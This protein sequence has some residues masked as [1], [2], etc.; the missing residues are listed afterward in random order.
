MGKVDYKKI[1]L[2]F[3]MDYIQK[4]AKEDKEWFKSIALDEEGKYNH[5]IAKR[6]FAERYMPDIIPKAKVTQKKSDLLKNW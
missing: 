3:M 6:Q 2:E 5:L 4:N 1:T